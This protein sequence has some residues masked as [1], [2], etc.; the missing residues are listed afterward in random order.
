MQ[1]GLDMLVR[2]LY[3]GYH[4]LKT[5]ER[6]AD[7]R[8]LMAKR[9][10]GSNP[11]VIHDDFDGDGRQDYAVLLKSDRSAAAE[12][13]ILL[14]KAPERCHGVYNL[15]ITG[16]EGISYLSPIPANSKIIESDSAG[17][18]GSPAL[19]LT[20]VAVRLVYFE[21]GEIALYWNKQLKKI[22]EVATGD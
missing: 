6:D 13:A 8:A 1:T 14:C 5:T 7:T 20:T 15:D 11:S 12:L 18:N 9:F 3:P 19:R 17:E 21:K 2:R 16:A 22:V 4:L 10:A